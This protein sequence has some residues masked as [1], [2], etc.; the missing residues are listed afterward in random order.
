LARIQNAIVIDLLSHRT[1][2]SRYDEVLFLDTLLNCLK[3]LNLTQTEPK[4]EFR[5]R[6]EYNHLMYA[7]IAELMNHVKPT[8]SKRFGTWESVLQDRIKTQFEGNEWR[9]LIA[10]QYQTNS[11]NFPSCIIQICA[12]NV[13][14]LT[15]TLIS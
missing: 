7:A 2:Y 11:P 9:L 8:G 4:Y 14:R 15:L 6:Y 3:T 5:T 10:V 12:D 13:D 1:G